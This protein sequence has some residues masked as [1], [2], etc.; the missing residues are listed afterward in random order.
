MRKHP[1]VFV[2][3][4]SICYCWWFCV[5]SIRFQRICLKFQRKREYV[6]LTLDE[7]NHKYALNSRMR[8]RIFLLLWGKEK[9]DMLGKRTDNSKKQQEQWNVARGQRP[10]KRGK[11]I[12]TTGG[13][14]GEW[15]K[16]TKIKSITLIFRIINQQQQPVLPWCGCVWSLEYINWNKSS[17]AHLLLFATRLL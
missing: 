12:T 4:A 9:I 1:S 17:S 14:G 3:F 5:S 8:A 6:W 2:L 10:S 16:T 15:E 13:E 7:W 11:T